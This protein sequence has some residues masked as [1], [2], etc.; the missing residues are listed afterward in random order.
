MTDNHTIIGHV[1]LPFG[2]ISDDD[3]YSIN[4]DK[5]DAIETVFGTFVIHAEHGMYN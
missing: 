3:F 4:I 2:N 1:V 5:R